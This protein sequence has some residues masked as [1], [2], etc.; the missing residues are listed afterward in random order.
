MHFL[1]SNSFDI[2]AV[3]TKG[4]S[5]IS[6]DEQA[7]A[8]LTFAERQ[9]RN[10]TIPNLD[11]APGDQATLEF[12]RNARRQLKEW[13]DPKNKVV[14][15]AM[16]YYNVSAPG[17]LNGYQRRL[18]YQLVRTE[19][20]QYRAFLPRK[21]ADFVQIEKMDPEKEARVATSKMMGFEAQLARQIGFRWIFEALVGADISTM[22]PNWF[23]V[24]PDGTSSFIDTSAKK[25]E[26]SSLSKSLQSKRRVLVGH[27]LFTDLIFVYKTFVGNLPDSVVEFQ[28]KVH[29]LFPSV[30]DTK[31]MATQENLLNPGQ[32]S[33]LQQLHDT[34]K[35]IRNPVVRL[36]DGFAAYH[37]RQVLHEAGYDSWL[38]AQIFLKLASKLQAG[39][40]VREP[41]I[42]QTQLD[43]PGLQSSPEIEPASPDVDVGDHE[44]G[45]VKLDFPLLDAN[46]KTANR[47]HVLRSGSP[48]RTHQKMQGTEVS[49]LDSDIEDDLRNSPTLGQQAPSNLANARPKIAIFIKGVEDKFWGIYANKLRVYGTDS[50]VCDLNAGGPSGE[51]RAQ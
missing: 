31:Y 23:C 22:D 30:I 47:F 29:A 38:T 16:N 26:I 36:A 40:P 35:P 1:R 14:Q 10:S 7:Q 24:T 13:T 3:F 5:F 17:G 20:K 33:G 6:R 51:C 28:Q 25:L 27:N 46:Q 45:G 18:V 8:R 39:L 48:V 50:E 11:I 4:V 42:S 9:N 44:D 37:D 43:N 19:F 15:Q 12:Y 49:L 34:L 41:F 2:G 32:A 21:H